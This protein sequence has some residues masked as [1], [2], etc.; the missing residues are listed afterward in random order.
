[1]SFLLHPFQT[2]VGQAVLERYIELENEI[3]EAE[4]ESPKIALEQKRAQVLTLREKI[5][6][7]EM[8]VA[9]LEVST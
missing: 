6:D 8:I 9:E 2:E 4:T 1:M 5:M 3:A 7:Q